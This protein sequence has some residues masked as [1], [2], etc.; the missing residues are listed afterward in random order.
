MHLRRL[1][2]PSNTAAKQ[3]LRLAVGLEEQKMVRELLNC[4]STH[5]C[6]R[7]FHGGLPMAIL[8]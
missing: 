7:N 2:T 4:N 3:T 8:E 1:R 6:V 5:A